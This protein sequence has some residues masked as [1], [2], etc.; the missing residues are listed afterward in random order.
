[1]FRRHKAVVSLETAPHSPKCRRNPRLS[2]LSCRF[3][4]R[5]AP[6]L[7]RE[8][9]SP[10]IPQSQTSY[11][12][13]ERATGGAQNDASSS[14]QIVVPDVWMSLRRR[15]PSGAHRC[16]LGKA[17]PHTRG[18]T[19]FGARGHGHV[20]LGI[21]APWHAKVVHQSPVPRV[22]FARANVR[23]GEPASSSSVLCAV[24]DLAC[25]P[26][27]IAFWTLEPLVELK[28]AT[29][30]AAGQRRRRWR[31]YLSSG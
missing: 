26:S 18:Q 29:V 15:D 6:S 2:R 25:Q 10:E 5:P 24:P 19:Q 7:A 21:A 11:R 3:Y 9:L 16:G 12:F 20:G 27:S 8:S 28:E 17:A 4:S 31:L 13:P 1:M 30:A 23:R 22:A 14:V